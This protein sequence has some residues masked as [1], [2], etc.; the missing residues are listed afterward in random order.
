MSDSVAAEALVALQTAVA[1]LLPTAIP[2]GLTR[3]LRVR[4]QVVRP[5]GLG[6]YVGRHVAPDSSLFGRRVAARVDLDVT[7]GSDDAAQGYAAA[8]AGEILG[9]TPSDFAQRGI[10]RIRGVDAASERTLAFDI[11]FEYVHVPA[12]S[13]GLITDL[14]LATFNNVTPYATRLLAEFSAPTLALAVDPL[15]DFLP[16]TDLQAAPPAAWAVDATA[17]VQTAA[18]AGGPLT[19]ADPEKAGAQLLWR[20][21]GVALDLPRFVASIDFA[22]TSANGIGLVFHRLAADDFYFFLAS[23]GN[24][25]HLIGRRRPAGWEAIASSAAGFAL[26]V[27]HRLILVSYDGA[28]T[29]DLD[30]RRT[31]STT[32]DPPVGGE[33][34][35]LT[36]GNDAARFAAGR[37]MQ[38]T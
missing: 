17:L 38:L 34:G 4:A 10:R 28:M 13:E 9:Q 37:L 30:D 19:L 8:L 2:V 11:D 7:G 20:P 24:G 18:T 12:A 22:S 23:Q 27:P 36:H 6:G 31:L 15:A 32:T 25:Y 5:L 1:S 33:V 14:A 3:S 29:V 26:G 21:K 35:L 16:F